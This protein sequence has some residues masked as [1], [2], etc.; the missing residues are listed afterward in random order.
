MS[1]ILERI[2]AIE[3]VYNELV[4][5]FLL[6]MLNQYRKDVLSSLAVEKK[7]AH[8]KQI[9]IKQKSQTVLQTIDF[10]FILMDES[11]GKSIS[12]HLI[13]GLVSKNKTYLN[14]FKKTEIILTLSKA[15]GLKVK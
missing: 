9:Q 15:Y 5:K 7:M 12:N 8:R 6:V 1:N 3:T 14:N 10:N 13:K 11:G 4:E 2:D